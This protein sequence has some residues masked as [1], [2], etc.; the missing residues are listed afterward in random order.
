MGPNPRDEAFV[1]TVARAAVVEGLKVL[2]DAIERA[3]Y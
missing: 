2:K 3:G 1:F